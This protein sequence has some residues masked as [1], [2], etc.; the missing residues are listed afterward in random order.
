ME[1]LAVLLRR[2][3]V[4]FDRNR[5]KA[6]ILAWIFCLGGWIG[7]EFIP[8]QF[9]S[10]TRVYADADAILG[11]L[12]RGIAVDAAPSSQV[13]TLQRTLLSRPNL[14]RVIARTDLDMRITTL[15][16]REQL[17]SS[18][19]KKIRLAQ[20]GRSNL[21]TIEY[22]DASPT[23]A[24]DVVQTILNIFLESAT[25]NDR[26]QM[27]NARTFVAS[28]LATYE[29]QLRDAE[30]RRAEFQ[31][32]YV[33]LLP[34]DANGGASRLEG[35]RNRLQQL[36]G[37]LQDGRMR[38]DLTRQQLESVPQTLSP[39]EVMTANGRVVRNGGNPRLLEA[40]RVLREMRLRYTDEHPDV[41]ATRGLVAEL[42]ANPN[43]GAGPI[44]V[45]GDAGGRSSSR[46]GAIANPLYEQ[47]RMRLVDT[48]GGLASLERQ[49]R[50][51]EAEV[52]RLDAVARTIP[53][54]IAQF[55]NLNRDYTVIQRQYQELLERREAV[56]VANAAR[57][58]ADRV[59]LEVIDPP[60]LPNQPAGPNR[61]LLAIGVLAVGVGAALGLLLLLQQLD[62]AFYSMHDLRRLGL[63]V[64][65]TISAPAK[66]GNIP[67]MAGFALGA[68]L[69]LA[70]FA[71]VLAGVPAMLIGMI[72]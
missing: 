14:E 49:V 35:G 46:G 45:G 27:D 18:L 40:E 7:I 50:D 22:T 19:G 65:G 52:E 21:F 34:S 38:R 66:P 67:A 33:D 60:N 51:Q 54:V 26:Q 58:S 5:W 28:Q 69:L 30:R 41:L 63:P 15:A 55:T 29:T 4:V 62:T 72:A 36:R 6:L 57:T 39:N 1:V 23:L 61:P 64:L 2:L 10:S 24:R 16:S 20:Q 70:S 17:I 42:R 12:L 43:L 44:D 68:I 31:A 9:V 3:G 56:Q 47:L 53:D 71:A 13:E 37:E 25:S 32:R 11:S 59:R 48:D 8:N